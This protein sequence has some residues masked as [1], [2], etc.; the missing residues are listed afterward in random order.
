MRFSIKDDDLAGLGQA[1]L[2]A[3]SD[4]AASGF[5]ER[6]SLLWGGDANHGLDYISRPTARG[7]EH[8]FSSSVFHLLNFG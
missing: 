7:T 3:M 8:F 1:H 4:D 2:G 5:M 6:S